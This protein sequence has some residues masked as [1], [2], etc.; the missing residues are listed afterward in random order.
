MGVPW[1]FREFQREMFKWYSRG[2]QVVSCTFIRGS[3][4]FQGVLGTFQG[5]SKS[6]R[7]LQE[8]F[9]W[10]PGV[11]RR[12]KSLSRAFHEA[13]V[14]FRDD[15]WVCQQISQDVPQGFRR[16]KSVP[17]SFGSILGV[18]KELPEVSGAFL[19]C[20]RGSQELQRRSLGLQ[21]NI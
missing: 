1:N 6:F 14:G 18:F 4:R 3:S 19:G 10:V 7:G 21:G 16:S 2:P 8:H 17:R 11:H 13:S 5:F 9:M 12:S 20:S 15:P